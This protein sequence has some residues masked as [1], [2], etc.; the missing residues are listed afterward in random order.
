MRREQENDR[1]VTQGPALHAMYST[2]D[3][4]AIVDAMFQ[5]GRVLGEMQGPADERAR[6]EQA[7]RIVISLMKPIR[8]RANDEIDST[9]LS[10]TPTQNETHREVAKALNRVVDQLYDQGQTELSYA[11]GWKNLVTESATLAAVRGELAA[12][13][14]IDIFGVDRDSGEQLAFGRKAYKIRDHEGIFIIEGVRGESKVVE[15]VVATPAYIE[16]QRVKPST[17]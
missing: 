17:P 14:L 8:Q 9:D 6:Q 15:I 11:S 12:D 4:H 16:S 3:R 1:G 10:N 13:T 2:D 5:G 7:K